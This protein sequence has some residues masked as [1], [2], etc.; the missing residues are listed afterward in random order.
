MSELYSY[1]AQ[2]LAEPPQPS[3]PKES[4]SGP[5]GGQL[6]ILMMGGLLVLMY[7]LLIYPQRKEDKRKKSMLASLQKGDSIVTSSGIVGTIA[8]IKEDRVFVNVGDGTRIEF[9][10]SA[11][12]Q[13]IKQGSSPSAT[14]R[15]K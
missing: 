3:S 2:Q 15:K 6:G 14:E 9:L 8:S 12:S 11:I 13:V 4:A 10:R 1:L 7:F 5:F